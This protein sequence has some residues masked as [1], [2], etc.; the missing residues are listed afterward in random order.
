[1]AVTSL[2]R[3]KYFDHMLV[4]LKANKSQFIFLVLQIVKDHVSV[5]AYREGGKSIRH[6]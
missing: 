2:S 3:K 4:F 5:F 6:N 1:M